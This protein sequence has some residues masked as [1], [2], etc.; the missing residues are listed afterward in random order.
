MLA[1]IVAVCIAFAPE[2]PAAPP[3]MREPLHHPSGWDLMGSAPPSYT[4]EIDSVVF[5]SGKGSGRLASFGTVPPK[6]FGATG[7]IVR[8]DD[9]VGKRV[10]FSAYLKTKDVTGTGAGIWMRLDGDSTTILLDNMMNRS[11][12]GTTDWTLVS[13]VLDVPAATAGIMLGSMLVGPGQA[14][15]DDATLTVVG[16]DVSVTAQ[17]WPP[18]VS[19]VVQRRWT[20]ASAPT[21]LVN[22]GFEAKP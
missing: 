22:G 19:Q 1:G 4:F 5:H 21:A 14:W 2:L 3:A 16:N 11:I 6:G 13:V 10:R 18:G 12:K 9:F 17:P 8:I 15:A 20:Y 7:Q